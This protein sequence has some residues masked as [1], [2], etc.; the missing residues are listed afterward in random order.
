MPKT[1]VILFEAA[2]STAYGFSFTD[3]LKSITLNP[4]ILLG[5]ENR[6][7]SIDKG[8]DADLVLFDGD[9]FEYVTKV[10][11]VIIDGEVVSDTCK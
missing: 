5:I 4:A 2:Q 3:A 9:P 11:T 6:V 10:C 1:R 8:K 7:G